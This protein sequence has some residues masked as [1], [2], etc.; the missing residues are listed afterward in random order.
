MEHLQLAEWLMELQMLRKADETLDK[1][2]KNW[3]LGKVKEFC[4]N[5]KRAGCSCVEAM[6]PFVFTTGIGYK[7]GLKEKFP[8]AWDLTGPPQF[9]EQEVEDAKVLMRALPPGNYT[10]VHR[11][12][13]DIKLCLECEDNPYKTI[14]LDYAMFPSVKEG[15]TVK[16]S[17][18]IGGNN[19]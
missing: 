12:R 8:C 19:D 3:T 14:L 11:H 16:L 18:I 15:E 2:R 5:V 6:C 13:A 4:T 10:Q 9:T 17:D 1:H 7:C